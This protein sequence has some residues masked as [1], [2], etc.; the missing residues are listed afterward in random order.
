[1]APSTGGGGIVADTH[2]LGIVKVEVGVMVRD[3]AAMAD[4]YG[5]VIGLEYVGDL[6][7]PGG[8]MRRYAHGDAV[9]KLVST[10]EPPALANPPGGPMG[11]ASGL[12]YLSLLVDNVEETVKRCLDA[13]HTVPVPKLEFEPGVFI[14][15]VE[16]PEGNWV[17]LLQPPAA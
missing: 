17:E 7:F 5:D 12:R 8:T 9:V 2:G 15:M 6:D 4:F 3:A 11:G 1:M 16:D 13:G 14:A 10:G